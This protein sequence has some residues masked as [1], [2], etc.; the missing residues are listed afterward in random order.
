MKTNNHE[1]TGNINLM[2]KTD[3]HSE[4]SIKL[5]AHTQILKQQ[6]QLNGR[7]HTYLSI[8]TLNVN[9]LNSSIKRHPLANWLEIQK[10]RLDNFL[11]SRSPYY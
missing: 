5:A 9:R 10:G 2:R 4:Y 6:K 3:K 8:L 1:R 11:F 7:N